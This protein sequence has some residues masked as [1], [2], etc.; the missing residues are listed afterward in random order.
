VFALGVQHLT[1]GIHESVGPLAGLDLWEE[2]TH[3]RP[4]FL[5]LWERQTADPGENSQIVGDVALDPLVHEE[6]RSAP[7]FDSV[8]GAY[9]AIGKEL[10][11]VNLEPKKRIIFLAFHSARSCQ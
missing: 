2:L 3:D 10:F 8:H 7:E 9:Q 6:P 4:G 5:H 1:L 11:R